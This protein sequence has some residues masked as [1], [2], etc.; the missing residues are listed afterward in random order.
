[1][2][3]EDSNIYVSGLS[4]AFPHKKEEIQAV[5][6]VDM[7]FRKGSFTAIIGESGCGKS[8]FGQAILGILP[9]Y[10]HKSGRIMYRSHNILESNKDIPNFYGR[11]FAIIPQNPGNALNPVRT[12]RKQMEDIVEALGVDDKGNRRKIACLSFFGITE[13]LRI[14]KSYP[15]E[16]SGGLHQRVLCAMSIMSEPRW[17]LADEPTKGMDEILC[18]LVYANLLLLKEKTDCSM[19]VITHDIELAKTVCDNVAIMYAGQI[20]EINE[21]LFKHP[22]H[23]YTQL[24]LQSLPENGLVAMKGIS[25]RP[26]TKIRGCRFASRCPRCTERCLREEPP[27]YRVKGVQVRCFLYTKDGESDHA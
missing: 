12:I 21:G 23:P 20:M 10:V 17:I 8:V 25:P 9:D 16:L 14:L 11:E 15:H 22:L 24:F 26:G 6:G 7:V 13:P 19:I 2:V 27:L 3:G 1:M 4:V 18:Q 5:A